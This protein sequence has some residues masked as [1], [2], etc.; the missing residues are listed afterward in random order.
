MPLRDMLFRLSLRITACREDAEDIVQETLLR[1]WKQMEQGTRIDSTDALAVTICRR[2]SLD[3]VA[4]HGRQNISLDEQAHETPDTGRSPSDRLEAQ[5]QRQ[6][7]ES[8]LARLPEKQRTALQ[9]RDIEGYAY[10]DIARMMQI[11][12]AD[13]KINIFRARQRL[14]ALL[15]QQ[16]NSI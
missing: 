6:R 2:L 11:S 7:I 13:A 16:P 4:R 14:R 5:E 12:E 15:L 8:L 3:T 10:K 1:L 9:L